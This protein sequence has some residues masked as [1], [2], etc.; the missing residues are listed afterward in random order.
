M[1]NALK[2]FSEA[3]KVNVLA[4]HLHVRVKYMYAGV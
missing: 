3:A 2:D 4:V 1:E